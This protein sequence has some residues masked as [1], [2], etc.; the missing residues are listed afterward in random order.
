MQET[1]LFQ[2]SD[3]R[4]GGSSG[5]GRDI[6]KPW[7]RGHGLSRWIS[8]KPTRVL[9]SMM[10]DDVLWCFLMFYD[11]LW[12]FMMF[13]DVFWCFMMF[14]DV[15][16]CFWCFLMF[17]DVFWCFMMFLMFSD[18]WW[19]FMMFSEGNY[20]HCPFVKDRNTRMSALWWG[21]VI[22]LQ[23]FIVSVILLVMCGVGLFVARL[24]QRHISVDIL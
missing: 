13:Y 12:C 15:L 7:D 21:L 14:S 8:G 19:C 20:H 1:D 22:R 4:G 2:K 18:I 5:S 23:C 9:W 3:D 6:T 17:Y 11:V 10:F 24:L 16:W